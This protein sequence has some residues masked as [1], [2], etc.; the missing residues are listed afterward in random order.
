PAAAVNLDLGPRDLSA[1]G[2]AGDAVL[3]T[4]AYHP[5]GCGI[6]APPTDRGFGPKTLAVALLLADGDVVS[7]HES[8]LQARRA[9]LDA[10][11]PLYMGDAIPARRDQPKREAVR[12]RERRIIH[13][14]AKQVLGIDRVVERHAAGKVGKECEVADRLLPHIAPDEHDFDA[15]FQR[16]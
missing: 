1:P 11:E 14:P 2:R 9:G 15:V 3:R 8:V 16:L 13:L 4:L 7:A 10:L 6:D 5:A 12:P